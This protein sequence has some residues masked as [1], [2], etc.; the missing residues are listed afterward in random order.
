MIMAQWKQI[1][2][3]DGGN[4]G[5]KDTITK[6]YMR[7]PIVFA[8]AFNKYLYHGRQVKKTEKLKELIK[9]NYKWN[10][11]TLQGKIDI[12]TSLAY[13][14]NDKELLKFLEYMEE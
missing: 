14:E 2:M 11:Y 8:D 6:E 7:N 5:K 12:V 9:E 13:F 1:R 3:K 4:L 10:D